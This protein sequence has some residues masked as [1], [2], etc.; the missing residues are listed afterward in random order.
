MQMK[1]SFSFFFRL[2]KIQFNIQYK[3]KIQ[4]NSKNIKF[5][6]FDFFLNLEKNVIIGILAKLGESSRV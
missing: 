3:I 1:F 4:K 5:E 2:F 6:I